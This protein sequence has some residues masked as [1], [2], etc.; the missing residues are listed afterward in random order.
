MTSR[1]TSRRWPRLGCALVV[2]GCAIL[3]LACVLGAL[4]LAPRVAGGP[5]VDVRDGT[6]YVTYRENDDEGEANADG[7]LSE[8][9]PGYFIAHDWSL[10]GREILTR[11]AAVSVDGRLY[12]YDSSRT[13]P[14]DADAA[15][16]V[17]WA[18]AGGGVG[19]QTC[20]PDDMRLVARYVPAA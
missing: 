12:R 15:E 19:F 20:T 2:A 1:Q 18:G 9:A 3:A 14:P 7:T 13:Y 10:S 17:A 16:A 4:W 11:P 6:W 8:W 5:P